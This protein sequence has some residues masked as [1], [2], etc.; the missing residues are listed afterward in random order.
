MAIMKRDIIDIDVKSGSIHRSFLNKM[1]GGGDEDGDRFG[2]R[3]LDDGQPVS[4][5]GASCIGYFIRQDGATLVINGSISGGVAYVELPAAA[6][7]IEGQFSLAI[8]IAGTGYAGTMRI[9]D[10]TVVK[11]TTGNMLDPASEVPSL[12]SL[13]EVISRAETAAEEIGD[14]SVTATKITGTRYKIAVT[15]A[16]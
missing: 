16:T 7:S 5:S 8:K 12:E 3:L 2:M 13:M 11:T 10:G 9:V 6:Y 4:L 15:I 1:I 14:L